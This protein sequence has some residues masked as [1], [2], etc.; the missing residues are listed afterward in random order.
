MGSASINLNFSP[1]DAPPQPQV[2]GTAP[3]FSKKP[4]IRQ[5][6]D[7]NT[8]VF[9]CAI[10]ADPP[11][12]ITWYHNGVKVQ[13][14][15]KYQVVTKEENQYTFDSSLI[16]R[17]VTV[18]DAGKY[19]VTARN[20]L[21]ESNATISL[22]FDSDEAAIPTGGV[23]PTFTERPVI[24]QS[25]EGTKIIFQCRL[26]GEPK[27]NLIWYH[28]E[29]KVEESGRV[30]MTV[31]LDKKMYYLCC[32]EISNVEAGDAGQY[33]AIAK[34]DSGESQATI[35]LTFDESG[36]SG[37]PKI[38]DGVAPRFPNKPTIRQE[39]DNLV[40]ECQ[41]EAHPMPEIT[42]YRADK[43]VEE[44][45]RIRY[46]CKNL[47][48][49]M[50]LLTLTITNP[51]MAD[52]GLYRCNAFNPFGDSNAN[53]DLNFETGEGD[54]A[55]QQQM[56]MQMQQSS[57]SSHKQSST[58]VE[59]KMS[60]TTVEKK[61]STTVVQGTGPTGDGFPPTFTE[62]PRIVPNETGTL[63]TMRFKVRSKPKA[64]MQWYKGSQ[65]IKEGAKFAVKY[66]TLSSDEYEIMLEISKPCGD[67]GGDY[68]CMMKNDFGQ[69][70][71]KLNLNIEAEPAPA[72]IP[73]GQAPTFVEKP[74]IVTRED[75]KLIMMIVRYRAEFKSECVW[76]FKETTISETSVMKL[77][78][79]KVA[80]FWESRVELTDPAPE[81]AGMYKCVV[82]NKFGEINANLS[83]N[84]EIA[85]VIRERPI[86]KKVE[87]KRSEVREGETIVQLEIQDTDA[88][89][90]GSYQ[91][92]AKSETGE[93]QSQTV[94][95]QEDQVKMEAAEVSAEAEAASVAS[96]EE[97]VKKKKKVVKKKKKK[98]G[99]SIE[100]KCRLEEDYEEGEWPT[101][102]WYFNGQKIESSER[103]LISFDGTY[104]TLFIASC[105][106]DDMG[107]FKVVFENKSGSDESTG[108]VTVKPDEN[109]KKEEKKA[110]PKPEPKPF[111]MP[112]KVEKK[113]EPEPEPVPEEPKKIVKK[114]PSARPKEE[115]KEEEA[116]F[117]M[118]L[119]KTERVQREW[120]DPEMETVKLAHHEFEKAP[121]P[122]EPEGKSTVKL[123]QPLEIED[124]GDD[125][126]SQK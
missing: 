8:L 92:V 66:N 68:K 65:K 103:C 106:M 115:P 112:K 51:S 39:G 122:V 73:A 81:N 114:K 9:H 19:K 84:I 23:K 14:T 85:P 12:M 47:G 28:G 98:E 31:K 60:S 37:K 46:E 86:I 11:P 117:A 102:T 90:Q 125:E 113:P 107:D 82:S 13:D 118:K 109:K 32:L 15:L 18:E 76:S 54:A 20:D 99:E 89:D 48:K 35:N 116:P 93:T 53:I 83:L 10:V 16:M 2:D 110:E 3:T 26:A 25:D 64:E 101:M 6:D 88:T 87:K 4:T 77:V 94:T 61:S 24:R 80:D 27:P 108:K 120:K 69:L 41:L 29:K 75:G 95:L 111:K 43:R 7:G 58:V 55:A 33:K 1:V 78:H 5:E 50:M 63:V 119:K 79:E 67:D 123:G 62:K 38:P 56:Q 121:Q 72:A 97:S 40:M 104:A 21:G 49:H 30:K 70:Q 17:N 100:M 36:G 105:T 74:K 71:A 59:K 42:W 96:T 52:G 22:N 44:N 45:S 126:D 57:S 91:L 124:G 34:N